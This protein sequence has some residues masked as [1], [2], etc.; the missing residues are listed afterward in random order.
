MFMLFFHFDKQNP[1]S[2]SSQELVYR[3]IESGTGID[4]HNNDNSRWDADMFHSRYE[5]F[6]CSR[7]ELFEVI[8]DPQILVALQNN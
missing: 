3:Q 6:V 4:D 7:R 1:T 8:L 2:F 5:R